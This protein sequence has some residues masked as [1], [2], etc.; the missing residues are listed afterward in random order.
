MLVD[1]LAYGA[2][3]AVGFQRVYDD[4]HWLSDVFAGAVLGTLIGKTIVKLNKNN[5]QLKLKPIID[6]KTETMGIAFDV[7][8]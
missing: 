7:S 8:F 2:A 4:N 1:I 3:S 6:S 5:S